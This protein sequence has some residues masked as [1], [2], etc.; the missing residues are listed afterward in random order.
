MAADNRPTKSERV[1]EGELVRSSAPGHLSPVRR[2]LTR[3]VSRLSTFPFF[4]R[5]SKRAIDSATEVFEAQT[6]LGQ[7]AGRAMARL[8]SASH[9]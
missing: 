7:G 1:I 6:R 5:M 9:P 3:L 8:L 2:T 4:N